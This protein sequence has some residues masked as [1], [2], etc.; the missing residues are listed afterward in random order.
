MTL[1]NVVLLNK[2]IMYVIKKKVMFDYTLY[3]SFEASLLVHTTNI[4]S[5]SVVAKTLYL[6]WCTIHKQTANTPCI[7]KPTDMNPYIIKKVAECNGLK[8]GKAGI[9]L[10]TK[11]HM[12]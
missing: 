4:L 2:I 12:T 5:D 3:I 10:L 11:N 7:D 8:L 9:Y 6:Q 1:V